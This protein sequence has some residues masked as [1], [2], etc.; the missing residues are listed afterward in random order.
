[1]YILCLRCTYS[2][3]S[4][5]WI[6]NALKLNFMHFFSITLLLQ[7]RIMSQRRPLCKI[8][9]NRPIGHE[10][11]INEWAQIV[12]TI[13]CGVRMADIAKILN[14]TLKTVWTTV[15][16]DSMRHTNKALSRSGCLKKV[17]ERDI[18]TIIQYV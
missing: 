13:K 2:I 8:S 1:M 18:C 7:Q 12:S 17:T 5:V 4:K 10:L 3:H 16:R 9:G 11:T 6:Q 14:F 15:Q